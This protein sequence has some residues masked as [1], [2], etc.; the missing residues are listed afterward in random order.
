M[1]KIK[2]IGLAEA[3][4][5]GQAILVCLLVSGFLVFEMMSQVSP[6]IMATKLMD[7]FRIGTFGLGIMSGI[8]FYTYTA[9]QLPLLLWRVV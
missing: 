7:G 9:M 8:C 4:P 3:I 6:S 2:K 5:G 1:N